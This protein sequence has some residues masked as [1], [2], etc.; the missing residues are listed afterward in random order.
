MSTEVH[1]KGH[2][3]HRLMGRVSV[4]QCKRNMQEKIYCSGYLWNIR[5]HIC[6]IE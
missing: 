4:I 1:G 2:I 5:L 3:D 6:G